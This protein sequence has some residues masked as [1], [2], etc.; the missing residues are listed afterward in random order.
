MIGT[1]DGAA[2]LVVAGASQLK[3]LGIDTPPLA[4]IVSW[5]QVG[6]DPR[7]MGVGPIAAIKKAVSNVL[8]YYCVFV[9]STKFWQIQQI[10]FC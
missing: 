5:A 1:N 2:A 3:K 10:S 8:C 9:R 4:K 7:I 6:L